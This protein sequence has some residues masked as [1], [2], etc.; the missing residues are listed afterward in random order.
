MKLA[1]DVT[2][3]MVAGVMEQTLRDLETEQRNAAEAYAKDKT[4]NFQHSM[5]TAFQCAADMMRARME[6]LED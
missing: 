3:E 5:A 1:A 4:D 6:T 2:R